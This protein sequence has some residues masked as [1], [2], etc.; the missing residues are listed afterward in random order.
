MKT[1]ERASAIL[2]S[3]RHSTSGWTSSI[4]SVT[5]SRRALSEFT[6][7]VA[8]RI[9]P[10]QPYVN[11]STLQLS[12]PQFSLPQFSWWQRSSELRSLRSPSSRLLRISWLQPSSL[13]SWLRPSSL[14]L[15]LLASSLPPPSSLS[16]SPQLSKFWFSGFSMLLASTSPA[17]AV[18]T[19]LLLVRSLS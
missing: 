16:S 19:A 15:F 10:R 12:L 2:V 13:A 1:G 14:L 4:H 6:F 11:D 17:Q 8:S 18:L 3:C 5:R 9:M 7:H